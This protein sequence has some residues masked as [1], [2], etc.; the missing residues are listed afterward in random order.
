M[1]SATVGRAGRRDAER[2]GADARTAADSGTGSP[3]QAPGDGERYLNKCYRS[4]DVRRDQ[5]YALIDQLSE[6]SVE[7]VCNAFEISRSSFYE[8]RR[9]RN[10]IDVERLT[11]RAEVNRLFTQS[12]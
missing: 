3:L 1:G 10:R 7:M 11:L 2:Q 5:S 4:L 6:W 8:Y 12:R 9:R